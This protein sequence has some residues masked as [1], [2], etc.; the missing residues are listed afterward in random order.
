MNYQFLI[1]NCQSLLLQTFKL[2]RI[3]PQVS[4]RAHEYNWSS[5]ALTAQFFEPKVLN[6]PE[7]VEVVLVEGE[8]EQQHILE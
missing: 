2:C 5:G 7:T 6:V 4:L 8:T 3:F 1:H